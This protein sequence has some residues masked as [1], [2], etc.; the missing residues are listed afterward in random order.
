[1]NEHRRFWNVRDH[2]REL[3]QKD[4][5]REKNERCPKQGSFKLRTR[6]LE[7]HGDRVDPALK[8]RAAHGLSGSS[9][10]EPVHR[11]E[12]WPERGGPRSLGGL[13]TRSAHPAEVEARA[14][15]HADQSLDCE[16]RLRVSMGAARWG[17]RHAG[18]CRR[19][20]S[21]SRSDAVRSE[22][23]VDFN[24]FEHTRKHVRGKDQ[25]LFR[26]KARTY[27]VRDKGPPEIINQKEAEF[28]YEMNA[29]FL[30]EAN[31]SRVHL[32]AIAG[33]T[34]LRKLGAGTALKT[35]VTAMKARWFE[36]MLD[37]IGIRAGC[38]RTTRPNLRLERDT[39]LP[40][41]HI[42]KDLYS[43]APHSGSTDR[44]S[45]Q[46]DY[47]DRR[48]G[49]VHEHH[50]QERG[51]EQP[52][53]ATSSAFAR[54]A[55]SASRYTAG[56]GTRTGAQNT[57]AA[58]RPRSKA[59]AA[60]EA[61]HKNLHAIVAMTMAVEGDAKDENAGR[62]Q[63]KD[64]MKPI[65]VRVLTEEYST[66]AKLLL[67]SPCALE[68]LAKI[69]PLMRDRVRFRREWWRAER[70][71]G[72]G[73]SDGTITSA[74]LGFTTSVTVTIQSLKHGAKESQHAG[75]DTRQLRRS[76]QEDPTELRHR[77]PT[78]A[79]MRQITEYL[80]CI[81]NIQNYTG[82]SVLSFICKTGGAKFNSPKCLEFWIAPLNS[83]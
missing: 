63:G 6:P 67:F 55:A 23:E 1:M 66:R 32:S 19:H 15:D 20:S 18:G 70:E 65:W 10:A 22:Y 59:T 16:V 26:H 14:Y 40:G 39:R 41:G 51:E 44:S 42:R 38:T 71:S 46:R 25:C 29:A 48:G 54:A 68:N 50:A 58:P 43:T 60:A 72:N 37:M 30:R 13:S 2:D 12:V 49:G 73:A 79:Q 80:Q 4:V 78:V 61:G 27:A 82:T 33:S 77:Y 35:G 11:G 9:H 57:S 7:R 76:I 45:C 64:L 3:F 31:P 81:Q 53:A 74:D 69:H 83:V 52:R 24:W 5:C 8:C 17:G 36:S 56:W 28:D 34:E 75:S 62:V 47:L 21:E